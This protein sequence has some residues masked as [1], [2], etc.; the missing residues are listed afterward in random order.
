MRPYTFAIEKTP[1]AL[2]KII[3]CIQPARYNERLSE[4]R[5][6]L[7]EVICHIADFE[8]AIQDRIHSAHEYPGKEIEAFDEEKRAVEKHYAD[9]DLHHELEVFENRRRDTADFL[10]TLQPED[11]K[12]TFRHPQF[13]EMSIADQVAMMIGHDLY[14]LEQASQYLR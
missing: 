5:F 9:R 1:S 4:D 13:G 14:H 8:E 12:K 11:W 3:D 10:R 7:V 6:S 2:Y